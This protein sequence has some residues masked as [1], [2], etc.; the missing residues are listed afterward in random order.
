MS[1]E[2][3][4]TIQAKKYLGT[5]DVLLF[6]G[7]RQAGKTTI[8]RQLQSF[9]KEKNNLVYFLN[10]EDPDYLELLNKS[11]K[12]LFK[13]F[14]L[15]L[16]KKNFVLI[17][18]IQYLNNPS[19]FLKYFYDEYGGKIKLLVSGSSAFYIDK[20]FKDSLVGRKKI[21]NVRTL[22]FREFLQFKNEIELAQKNFREINLSEKEKIIIYYREYL[23]Y[24]GYPRVVLAA[25]DEK[26]EILRDIA[27]S[28]IKK[29]IYE[30]NI[31]QD[32]VFYK[33]F[34]ILAEQIGNLI[35][36]SELA[37][38]LGVSK[39][40]IDNY[41][42]VMRKSFHINL[43]KPFFKNTRKELT[44]MPKVYFSDL[45]LRNFFVSDFGSLET[46]KDKGAL[47]ENAVFK[48]LI[49]K[50]PE[51][52]I[53]F[54]RTIAK[55]EVDFVIDKKEA[56]EIKI[57]PLLFKES[58]YKIFFKNYPDINFS[59]ISLGVTNKSINHHKVLEVWEI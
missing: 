13:V 29:D 41:L 4:A 36:A 17:D 16:N 1:I 15:D 49:E 23:I 28:Y 56:L 59:L 52:K 30:A 10:L 21:F 50:Y 31:R 33:L 47:L 39:T 22:S 45:G 58:N 11:P 48:Q 19:N 8:L 27:Y 43:V 38:T 46:R 14:T 57:N 3:E 51:D 6:I 55:N 7:A 37:S 2:R 44:K 26:E 5:D 53:K 25:T 9:L 32:E 34:K 42:Y 20:K 40:S 54:W 24:G 18:E 12:N 35:N